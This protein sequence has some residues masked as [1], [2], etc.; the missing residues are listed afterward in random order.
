MG[1]SES[2]LTLDTK[3]ILGRADFEK[4][5]NTSDLNVNNKINKGA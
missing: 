3:K 1:Q 5:F 2:I 4:D